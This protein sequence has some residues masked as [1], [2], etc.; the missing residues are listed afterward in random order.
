MKILVSYFSA[1]DTTKKVAI[2]LSQSINADIYEIK[3]EVLYSSADLNWNNKESRSSVEMR[4]LDF[5]PAIANNNANIKD[6]D[7]IFIGFPIWWYVA[8]TIINTFMEGYDFSDKKVILFATSGGSGFGKAVQN[9][10][11]S[12]SPSTIIKEGKVFSTWS[13]KDEVSN[14][15]KSLKL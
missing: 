7:V 12:C 11:K 6:Y 4:N 3:P 14:W 9:L 13:S 1:T 10:K 15:V 5:R 8:P 2:N